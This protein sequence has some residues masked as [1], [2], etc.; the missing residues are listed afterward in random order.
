[1]SGSFAWYVKNV[2]PLRNWHLSNHSRPSI[3]TKPLSFASANLLLL[4]LLNAFFCAANGQNVVPFWSLTG[5]SNVSAASK[6]GTTNA[7]PLSLY[8]GN[9]TRLFINPSGNVGICT[10]NPIHRFDTNHLAAG[11]YNITLV[12]DGRTADTQAY[13]D[14]EIKS[15]YAI[16][17]SRFCEGSL[18]ASNLM[19]IRYE[20]LQQYLS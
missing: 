15:Y 13:G 16:R 4:I 1:V 20:K 18:F 12:V 8:T 10:T 2:Q 6:L 14:C 11:T 5:N 7:I 9:V 17:S 3:V 19:I